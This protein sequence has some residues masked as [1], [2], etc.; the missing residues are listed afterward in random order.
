MNKRERVIWI[1]IT[2]FLLIILVLLSFSP[3]VLAQS[4]DPKSQQM[5]ELFYDV[6]SYVQN[7]YVDEDKLNPEDLI[8]GAIDGMMKSLDDPHSVYLNP[9]RLRELTDTTT[10]EFFGIGIYIH[11]T[12]R[13]FEVARPITGTPAEEAGLSSGDLI[14]AIEG[15]STEELSLDDVIDKI[16][17]TSMSDITITILRG[18]S[19]I[20]DVT[21]TRGRI[22]IP[23]VMREMITDNIGYMLI[24][25]FTPMTLER[26]IDSIIYFMDK[27]YKNLIIDV[28]SNPGGLLTSVVDVSDLFFDSQQLIVSTRSR[29]T[30]ENRTYYAKDNSIVP[31]SISIVVLIDKYSASA[32]EILTG[33][34][35]DTGRALII[36]ET[37][38]GK[39][40]VQQIIPITLG[41]IKL[42]ISKYFTP[43][44]ISIDQIGIEPDIEVKIEEYTDEEISSL[45]TLISENFIPKF[46]DEYPNPTEQ[47]IALYIDSLYEQGMVIREERIRKG[48]RDELNRYNNTPPVYDLDYDIVLKEAVNII[49]GQGA[50]VNDF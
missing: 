41:G 50:L 43:S 49:N 34:L 8:Q 13:G 39:G 11:E 3:I 10:G 7:Y 36:G 5:L 12:D 19:E 42:T 23:T 17:G 46:I 2:G 38:Y 35:K 44:G 33:V 18:E 1:G 9:D 20:F 21:I 40:S 22:E 47:D 14:F 24:T 48:I 31:E 30:T 45:Q 28:R 15:E 25:E 27:N 37:S 16:R 29:I 4:R 32:S 26:V 6:F